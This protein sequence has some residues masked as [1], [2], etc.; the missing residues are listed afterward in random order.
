MSPQTSDQHTHPSRARMKEVHS[1]PVAS[2]RYGAFRGLPRSPREGR[3]SEERVEIRDCLLRATEVKRG[4][5]GVA[6]GPRLT[7]VPG[8]EQSLTCWPLAPAANATLASSRDQAH[9]AR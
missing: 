9:V 1:R 4:D 6:S 3:G 5:S 7:G 8:S 2:P